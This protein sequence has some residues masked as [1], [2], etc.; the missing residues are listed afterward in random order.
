M[1]IKV[2]DALTGI[3][4]FEESPEGKADLSQV[5]E[6]L[7]QRSTESSTHL[8]AA[9]LAAAAPNLADHAINAVTMAATGNILGAITNA[10]PVVIALSGALA[11]IIKPEHKGLTNDDIKAHVAALSRDE[12]IRLLG[13]DHQVSKA[14]S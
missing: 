14:S 7:S 3:E 2:V 9:V 5:T 11:A 8:G 4:R 12:L 1:Y 10:I 13:T 6:W